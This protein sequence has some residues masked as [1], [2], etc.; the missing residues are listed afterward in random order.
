MKIRKPKTVIKI[1]DDGKGIRMITDGKTK[2]SKVSDLLLSAFI[3]SLK[4]T[5]NGNSEELE[6]YKAIAIN[7]IKKIKVEDEDVSDNDYE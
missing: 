4:F 1:E 5:A 7:E 3:H 2:A 6:V